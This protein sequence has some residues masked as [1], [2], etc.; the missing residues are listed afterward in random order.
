[1]GSVSANVA[2]GNRAVSMA[3]LCIAPSRRSLSL[4]SAVRSATIETSVTVVPSIVSEPSTAGVRPTAVFAPMPASSS[5]TRYPTNDAV[6]AERSPTV[7]S[8]VHVPSIEESPPEDV[9]GS[10]LT[11]CVA[12]SRSTAGGASSRNTKYQMPNPRAATNAIAIPGM[13]HRRRVGSSALMGPQSRA[14]T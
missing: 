8:T 6:P 4:A 5:W 2:S 9:A 3:W 11:D 13:I 12:A 1:M 10:V 14:S 7:V